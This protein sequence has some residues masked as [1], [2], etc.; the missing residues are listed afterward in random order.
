MI[1]IIENHERRIDD[2]NN[3][4]KAYDEKNRWVDVNHNNNKTRTANEKKK[5][6]RR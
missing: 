1:L 5:K 6:T 4:I 2:T 3:I